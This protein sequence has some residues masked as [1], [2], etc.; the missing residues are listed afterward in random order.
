MASS[1]FDLLAAQEAMQ[2]ASQKGVNK[3]AKQLVG[4]DRG[5][6]AQAIGGLM[7]L[8]ALQASTYR[9]EMLAHAVVST[10]AGDKAP[11]QRDLSEWLAASG[12]AVG[13][14]EDP[15]EDV[16]LGRVTYDGEN[17]RVLEGL[18]EGG[19]FHLQV[20]LKIVENM[21]A[22][23]RELKDACQACLTL[24]EQMCERVGLVG[25]EVGAE[26]PIRTRVPPTDLPPVRTLSSWVT[27]SKAELSALGITTEALSSFVL[28]PE[29]FDVLEAYAGDSALFRKPV[30][31]LGE[32]IVVAL[33]TAIGP[34][35]RSIV[36]D[37]C[38]SL[39]PAGEQLFRMQHLSI[40]AN[41]M[42]ETPMID[43]IGMSPSPLTL[44]PVVPSP[45][46]EIDPGYWVQ[47]VIVAD[48]LSGFEQDG[49]MGTSQNGA[50]AQIE[51]EE[52][53]Q[54]ARERCEGS[55]NFKAG[56]T[57]VIF[58]GFGRGQMVGLPDRSDGWFVEAASAYDAEVLGWRTDF[59]IFDL[60]RFSMAELDLNS[61]GFEMPHV[62]GLLA[63]VGDTIR[64]G[65]HLIPHSDLPDGM[66]GGLIMGRT[67]G[68]LQIRVEHHQRHDR[69]IVCTPDGEFVAMQK[70]GTGARSPGGVSHLYV[71]MDDAR[72]RRFRAVWIQ[73]QRTW[74]VETRPRSKNVISPCYRSFEALRT[75]IQRIAPVLDEA[76]PELPD[77]LLWDM[78]I[79]PQP[80]TPSADLVPAGADDIRASI[81]LQC[82]SPGVITT[83]VAPE[84]WLGLSNDSNIAEATLVEAFLL[85]A[86]RLTGREESE[87][88][89]IKGRIVSSPRARQLHAFAPQDFRDHMRDTFDRRVVEISSIQDAAIRIGLGWSG[90]ERPGGRVYGVDA[91]TDALN[92][93]TAAAE[94]DLCEDL[95]LFS[96][97]GLI[98][99]AIRNHEAAAIDAR[100]WRK[101][102]GA[103]IALSD[104]ESAVRSE[105]AE[106]LFGL[107]GVSLAC[108]L[109]I[110]IG[111][112]HCPEKGGLEV[113]DI[114]LSRLMARVMMIVHLGGYSDAIQ[115]GAMK[116]ELRISPAGEVQIDITFFDR[117]MEP[118]GRAF[119][120]RQVD[121]ERMSY[122][123][124]L[125]EP[126][127]ADESQHGKVDTDFEMAWAEEFGASFW[128]Y[129]STMDE[130]EKLC[131]QQEKSWIILP[132]SELIALLDTEEAPK[133]LEM[134]ESV[135]RERWKSVPQG[136]DD[137]DRQPWRFKR[138][139]SI[140]R[141]P[142]VRLG[143]D[144][145][146]NVLVA[147][148]M[149][150]ESL[151]ATVH[152]MYE[153]S[154]EPFRLASRKM[155]RWAD[156]V[157]N[158]NGTD[159]EEEVASKLTDLGWSVRRGIKFGE[160]LGRHPDE[161]P[162]DI[163]VLAWNKAGCIM[164][165]ECKHL[166]FA[167][168][169]SEIAKQ[170]SKFRGE[171]DEKGRPDRLAKHLR[172][173]TLARQ[174]TETFSK[175]TSLKDPKIEAGLVF[176]NTVPMQF[177]VDR[178][179]EQLWTGT[180][181]QLGALSDRSN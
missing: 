112:H 103:I 119:T 124:S 133:V 4:F 136:Y 7:L 13:H 160:I 41:Q 110:E 148:G 175:F 165:L 54:S 111:L 139:L 176:S 49:L 31:C 159:F 107:N 105:I 25:F 81:D 98:E 5:V 29:F 93:I 154:Y 64:N 86:L 156:K 118:V 66:P 101:T 150:R 87:L 180:I 134:L 80:P 12:K 33:P 113:G 152:N 120:D 51:L 168:T 171:V 17:Y 34:A 157:S 155:R 78:K 116:P 174:N 67:N 145:D 127:L 99:A 50:K 36:I 92:K 126:E 22:K 90:V 97:Q 37:F 69:R 129:R 6:A 9:L 108:R 15:A 167:K 100:R 19:C 146:A 140:A 166:Q 96:R 44:D 83:T 114:D 1:P 63:Q 115:Y 26:D 46:V 123:V 30:L 141:R 77:F 164:L 72:N 163:D 162:G 89:S 59:S 158:A 18:S 14:H 142:I 143:M 61:K 135:P 35:I 172:R 178:M 117:I 161:D 122:S 88:A 23:F 125:R 24:S 75:W 65:G 128:A 47:V 32:H 60:L 3:F 82:P 43:S 52:A 104:N 70:E 57:F 48:D 151:S 138:R 73:S 45:P 153:G 109:L 147:P 56:L 91:C 16:F 20:L 68:Q 10:C 8:P 121:R 181:E 39:G 11:R 137:A 106:T 42:L 76:I 74:W 53:I 131:A 132:R 38:R 40:I 177:A 2:A 84:F 28:A 79:D 144:A 149:V 71:S 27:F 21:P 85:G 169:A 95:S 173:W 58:C 130:L 62:N 55:A 170:L 179:R 102:S 94:D